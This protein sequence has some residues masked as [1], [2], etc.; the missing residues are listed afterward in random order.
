M[1]ADLIAEISG[2]SAGKMPPPPG[3]VTVLVSVTVIT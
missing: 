1:A 2:S 3:S